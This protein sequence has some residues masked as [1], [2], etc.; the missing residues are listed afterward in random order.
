M[1]TL[2]SSSLLYPCEQHISLARESLH[3]PTCRICFSPAEIDFEKFLNFPIAT[4]DSNLLSRQAYLRRDEY[5]DDIKRLH[6]LVQAISTFVTIKEDI[7][8]DLIPAL[9]TKK[10]LILPSILPFGKTLRIPSGEK[11]ILLGYPE[12]EE[13]TYP[14]IIPASVCLLPGSI[15]PTENG[16]IYKS[17]SLAES[18]SLL[19]NK[20]N[21][22]IEAP[23]LTLDETETLE[24]LQSKLVE[25]YRVKTKG[26]LQSQ[27][28]SAEIYRLTDEDIFP[29]EKLLQNI[30]DGNI[31]ESESL[32]LREFPL[33]FTHLK[34]EVTLYIKENTALLENWDKFFPGE[35]TGKN[36]LLN[37]IL[38][39]KEK[40]E[41][42][43][44]PVS[45]EMRALSINYA[46]QLF[47]EEGEEVYED[48]LGDAPWIISPTSLI[49]SKGV[50][51][52]RPELPPST[53]ERFL[54][55]QNE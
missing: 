46:F 25:Y 35:E 20:T 39:Q 8:V 18:L 1:Q 44:F 52:C 10:Q 12:G 6:A 14:E 37:P 21:Y 11:I 45:V 40:T 43:N 50:I 30:L 49:K 31:G 48:F 17:F 26:G 23:L 47:D 34:K 2:K 51:H 55:K 36:L 22:S 41:E 9:G 29:I 16:L 4:Y 27:Q 7:Y 33:L 15:V 54:P 53:W 38:A 3:I 13:G 24:T 32:V 42:Y 28:G 19:D 5:K